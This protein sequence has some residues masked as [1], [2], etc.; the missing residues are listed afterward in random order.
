MDIQELY[1]NPSETTPL[2]PHDVPHVQDS[3]DVTLDNDHD[4]EPWSMFW[5][6]VR[7]LTSFTLPVFGFV[8]RFLQETPFFI[9]TL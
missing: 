1:N 3:S 5:E 7:V 4:A 9:I 2:I 8:R 6:E